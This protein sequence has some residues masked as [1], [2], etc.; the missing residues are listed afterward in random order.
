MSEG[1]PRRSR[2][3]RR[4]RDTIHQ[5]PWGQPVNGYPPLDLLSADEV[6][7]IHRQ[8]LRILKEI[9]VVFHS[10][11]ARDRFRAAGARIADDGRVCISAEMVEAA[12]ASVGRSV[13]LTP[14]N[15]ERAV[16]IGGNRLAFATVLGPPNCTDLEGGRRPG[17]LADFG[18]FV[19][20]AQYFNVIHLLAGSPVEPMDVP[21]PVRHLEST[22]TMLALS[23]KVPYVFC[24]SRRRVIDVL[25]M[26]E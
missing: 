10:P 2:R 3:P 4:D 17:S 26:I 19:R 21:V 7:A 11:A 23:D 22:R 6:E 16:T 1:K 5:S 8:S 18:D 25:E 24:H 13:V 14:R 9:G 20:L 12:L 15:P